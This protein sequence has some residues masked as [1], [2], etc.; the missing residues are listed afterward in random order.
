VASPALHQDLP[1]AQGI[2]YPPGQP[3]QQLC[4]GESRGLVSR[5]LADAAEEYPVE[6]RG[7]GATCWPCALRSAGKRHEV[8]GECRRPRGRWL[9]LLDDLRNWMSS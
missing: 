7:S 8:R 2:E 9:P 3:L 6:P 5:S 4:C 1:L